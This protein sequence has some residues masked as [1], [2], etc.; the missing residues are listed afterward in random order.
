MT[1]IEDVARLTGEDHGLTV[2]STVRPDGTVQSSVVNAGVLDHPLT[3]APALGFVAGGGTRKLANLR[4]RPRATAVVRAGWRWGAV[5][6]DVTVI[7]PDDP[8]G[9]IKGDELRLLL[10][11]VF[12]AAGGTHED[13]DTF[14]RTMAEERRAVVLVRPDRVYG[15]A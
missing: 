14:D 15:N 3:G 4:V 13:W 12:T 1:A 5:E 11:A 7:G 10:R 2:V 9:G 6:G 8:A